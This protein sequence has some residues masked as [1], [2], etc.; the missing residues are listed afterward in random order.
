MEKQQEEIL[1]KVRS[2]RG[3]MAVAFH[4]YIKRFWAMLKTVWPWL[5]GVAVVYAAIAMMI[6]YIN[7]VFVPLVAVAVLLELA[8]WVRTSCWLTQRPLSNVL[9]AAKKHWLLLIGMAVLGTLL[10]LPVCVVVALPAIILMLAQ[11]ESQYGISMGDP[12]SMPTYYIYL[13]A[14]TW[15]ITALLHV[16]IRLYTVFLGYYAWGSAETRKQEREQQRLNL[17]Q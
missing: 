8:L 12:I 6:D 2:G 5:I 10:T 3:V 15:F 1:M 11:W 17:I 4:L 14:A 7:Y 16:C 9:R 13:A